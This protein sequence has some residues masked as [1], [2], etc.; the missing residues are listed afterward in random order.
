[1][2]PEQKRLHQ[3]KCTGCDPDPEG[4][5]RQIHAGERP[6]DG[7]RGGKICVDVVDGNTQPVTSTAC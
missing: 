2:K 4:N 1:M 6:I 3:G 5:G 7:E